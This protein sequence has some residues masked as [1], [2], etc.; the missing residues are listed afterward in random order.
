MATVPET[1]GVTDSVVTADNYPI[2]VTSTALSSA[3]LHK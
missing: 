2:R 3:E 1:G